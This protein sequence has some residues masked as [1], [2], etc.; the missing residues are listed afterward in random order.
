MSGGLNHATTA[1]SSAITVATVTAFSRRHAN[2]FYFLFFLFLR[3][4]PKKSKNKI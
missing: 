3:A 2:C 4:S 1:A